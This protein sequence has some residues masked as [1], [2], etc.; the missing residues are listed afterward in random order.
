[1]TN[2]ALESAS[3]YIGLI[4][5]TSIDAIDAALVVVESDHVE[6]SAAH[7]HEIPPLLRRELLSLCHGTERELDRMAHA[8]AQLGRLFAEA[9]LE[10]LARAGL[11]AKR[12]R[13]IGSHGQTI[14]HLPG[15]AI[16]TTLQIG[17]PNVIAENTGITTVADFRRRDMAAGGQ[18]APLVPAFH[19]AMLH[20]PNAARAV[21]NIGGMANVTFLPADPST[22]VTG[23]DTG[24][25][26]VLMDLW[27]QEHLGNAMDEAGDWARRG[28]VVVELLEQW[29]RDSYFAL[30]PPKSTGREYFNRRWLDASAPLW[31]RHAPVDVQATLSE[32]TAQTIAQAIERHAPAT[33]DVLICGGGVHNRDLMDRL[34]GALAQH[35]VAP[36][37]DYG[38]DPD[39]MEAMAFAWLA[40]RTLHGRPGNLPGVTGARH[41]VVLGG[42]Y[43]VG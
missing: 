26:N 24:P 34:R 17:D 28:T 43:P 13:A 35:H 18:G 12:V 37:S 33:R 6:L 5:G 2:A 15:G 4:S 22:P 39:W 8:D 1:M 23:F 36:T 20:D 19:A 31:R 27:A 9:S 21:V 29:H 32:L 3:Y 30:P 7:S 25:G 38:I 40:H 11:P 14:R 16:P 41:A 10:L 42:I